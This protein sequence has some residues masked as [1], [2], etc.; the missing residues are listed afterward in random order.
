MPEDSNVL[1]TG[2]RRFGV[3]TSRN[4]ITE[5]RERE[6]ET[7]ERGALHERLAEARAAQATVAAAKRNRTLL[8]RVSRRG[9]GS[10]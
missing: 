10:L 5:D 1:R 8:R 6:K 4:S 3:A 7:S 2:A 9:G